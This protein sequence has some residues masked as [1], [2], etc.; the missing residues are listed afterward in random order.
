MLDSRDVP[1]CCWGLDSLD[2]ELERTGDLVLLEHNCYHTYDSSSD[3]WKLRQQHS[4]TD[5]ELQFSA[6]HGCILTRPSPQCYDI[7][8]G[9]RHV[10]RTAW[11]HFTSWIYRACI[12]IYRRH[13]CLQRNDLPSADRGNSDHHFAQLHSNLPK[14]IGTDWSKL[15]ETMTWI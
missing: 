5:I 1:R 4:S 6:I 13:V 12:C 3:W 10:E 9:D 15:L 8:P 7:L 2:V 11:I 14:A